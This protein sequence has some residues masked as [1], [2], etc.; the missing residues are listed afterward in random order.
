MTKAFNEKEYTM[1]DNHSTSCL[2]RQSKFLLEQKVDIH[3]FTY[4]YVSKNCEGFTVSMLA[5]VKLRF[6]SSYKRLEM[7][8]FHH[9]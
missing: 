5:K 8:H 1:Q 7:G 9:F 6:Q 4:F 3:I 2:S